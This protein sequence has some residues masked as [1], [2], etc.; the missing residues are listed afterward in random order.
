MLKTPGF[1]KPD[2]D[3]SH[4]AGTLGEISNDIDDSLL[5]IHFQPPDAGT[6]AAKAL[7]GSFLSYI[8]YATANLIQRM[9]N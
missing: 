8:S 3:K 7:Q 1:V 5:D 6:P 2:H 4:T 9:P